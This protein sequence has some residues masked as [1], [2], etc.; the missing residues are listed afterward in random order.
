MLSVTVAWS[1][2]DNNAIR[3][4]LP[5][6]WMTSCFHIM[7]RRMFTILNTRLRLQHLTFTVADGDDRLTMCRYGQF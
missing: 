2:S 6:L 1:S 7:G 4:V 5:V 3:Y